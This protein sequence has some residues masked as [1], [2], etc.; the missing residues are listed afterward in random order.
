LGTAADAYTYDV[1]G[2]IRTQSG[3][4][5]N[6]WLFTGEQRDSDSEFYYLRARYYDP[7]TGRF[8][9]QDPWAG[10]TIVPQS[11]NRYVYVLNNPGLYV[12]PY[13][14]FGLG[15]VVDGARNVAGAVGGGVKDA[16]GAVGEFVTETAPQAGA[17]ALGATGQFLSDPENLASVAQVVSGAGITITCTTAFF[18]PSTVGCVISVGVYG[19]ASGVK[20]IYADSTHERVFHGVTAVIG[21]LPASGFWGKVLAGLSGGISGLASPSPA[22]TPNEPGYY[23]HA[24]SDSYS[25]E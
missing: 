8:L 5:S 25:K 19:A 23:P 14:Y 21:G 12:D 6:Y 11:L 24:R 10:L 18:A 4:S 9:S 2:A 16:A 17:R 7:A 1:F 13:G 15:D 3:S 20:V 22:Y